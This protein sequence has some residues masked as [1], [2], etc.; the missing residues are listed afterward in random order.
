MI[1]LSAAIAAASA[2]DL[3]PDR[4]Q[5]RTTDLTGPYELIDSLDVGDGAYLALIRAGDRILVVP[6]RLDATGFRRAAVS[7]RILTTPSSGQFRIEQMNP[8]LESHLTNHGQSSES[9]ITVDQSN[10]S[11]IL[12][13]HVMLKWQINAT[14][15]PAP[16]R[17]RTLA[18][19]DTR[20]TPLPLAIIEWANPGSDEVLTLAT[21]TE[22]VPCAR[23]GWDW[24]VELVRAF[25]QGD[26]VDALTPFALIG[27]LTGQMHVA[28]VQSSS[29]CSDIEILDADSLTQFFDAAQA[30]LETACTL[31]EDNE[32]DRLRQ[33]RMLISQHLEALNNID[34]TLAIDSHGDFHVG[35]ILQ[36][37]T[38][39]YYIV[40]F[41]GNPVLPPQERLKKQPAARDIA[42][43]LASIDHV[44]RVVNHRTEGLEPQ[45]A[46]IWS[47]H[48]QEIFLKA[49]KE[50]LRDNGLLKILDER[51]IEPFMLHQE[52]REYIYSARHLR[53]WRYVPDA[54]LTS[55]FPAE[56]LSQ[57]VI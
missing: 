14:V 52:L 41:D 1:T 2:V 3:L 13:D 28:L 21:A 7:A 56:N 20:L 22:F 51:L 5:A 40:D 31:M 37:Q 23:D 26:G 11:V 27:Q 12:N 44:A 46:L 34:H 18:S 45:A 54:V 30:D 10:D 29:S 49:Y 32:G 25:A 15:S 57:G 47:S 35:Q 4:T 38:N 6:G 16:V 33:R 9:S 8:V 55:K 17:L 39:D 48:A 53:H 24:A 36:S 43:M 50:V 19:N 42:G